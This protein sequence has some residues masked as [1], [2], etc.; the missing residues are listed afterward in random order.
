LERLKS[1]MA[2]RQQFN[3]AVFSQLIGTKTVFA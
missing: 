3:A 2:K 1:H